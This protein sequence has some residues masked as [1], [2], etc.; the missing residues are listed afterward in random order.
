[1]V[2]EEEGKSFAKDI[3]SL[4][5]ETSAKSAT[6]IDDLFHY[7]GLKLIDPNFNTDGNNPEESLMNIR[8]KKN[9]KL[10]ETPTKKSKKEKKKCC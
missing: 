5:L 10:E 7:V 4:F 2:P 1:M 3:N 9:I 6:G 8:I